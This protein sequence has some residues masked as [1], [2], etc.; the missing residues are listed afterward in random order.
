MASHRLICSVFLL[1]SIKAFPQVGRSIMEHASSMYNLTEDAWINPALSPFKFS[2]SLSDISTG[3]YNSKCE[4]YGEFNANA[5]IKMG[6]LTLSANALYNNGAKHNVRF[7][8][9]VDVSKVYPY[10][11]YDAIGGNLNLERYGFAGSVAIDLNDR[12][13][14]GGSASYAAGLFYRNVDP[15]PRDIT[16]DLN[17]SAGASFSFTNDYAVALSVSYNKYKQSCDID[18]KSELGWSTIYHMTGLGSHYKRFAGQGTSSYY[19]GNGIGINLTLFPIKRG[20]YANINFTRNNLTHILDDLNKLPM[21]KINAFSLKSEV[22]FKSRKWGITAFMDI[23]RRHG[24]E[25]IF[26]DAATGQF[27]LI[28][29]LCMHIINNSSYGIYGTGDLSL[30]KTLISISPNV[31]YTHYCEIYREPRKK[32]V[33]DD[34]N[35]GIDLK[36][37]SCVSKKIILRGNIGYRLISPLKTKIENVATTEPDL[38]PFVDIIMDNYGNASHSGNNLAAGIGIDYLIH[39]GKY[40]I[41]LDASYNMYSRTDDTSIFTLTF[42]F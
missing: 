37:T 13:N 5:Y 9:N 24:Y 39:H 14:I 33:I 17:L 21:S 26:G 34:I 35:A 28:G 15:R 22:G 32:L 31:Y 16:G 1:I 30:G 4:R 41:G 12:W 40:A 29:S 23:E 38:V 36:M 42:K 27:P 19:N 7:C 10:L 18:F 3:F 11:T 2:L 8:E 25:N 6:N 20:I